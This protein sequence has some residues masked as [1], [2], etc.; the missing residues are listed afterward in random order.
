[1]TSAFDA[2]FSALTPHDRYKLLC[3]SLIVPADRSGHH[4]RP[5]R[6]RQCRAVL[7]FQRI[8]RRAGTCRPRVIFAGRRLA[9]RHIREY[10]RYGRVHREPDRRGAR[11]AHEHLGGKF[12]ADMSEIDAAQL[13]TLPSHPRAAGRGSAG[14]ARMRHYVTLEVSARRRVCLGEVLHVHARPGIVDPVRMHVNLERI[15]AGRAPVRQPLCRTRPD[16]RT[17]APDLRRMAQLIF[18]QYKRADGSNSSVADR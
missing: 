7:V 18:R 8:C 11:S 14:W 3:A 13:S 17:Q 16:L 5:R 6:H 12:P 10:S 1:V 2:D 15:Q 4:S 9:E